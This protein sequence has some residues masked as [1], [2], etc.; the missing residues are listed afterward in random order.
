MKGSYSGPLE[1]VDTCCYRIPKSYK[2]GMQF[3]K[4]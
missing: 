1:K 2:P 4:A 3:E